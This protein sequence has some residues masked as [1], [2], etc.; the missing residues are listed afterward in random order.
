MSQSRR[1]AAVLGV[2][3]LLALAGRLTAGTTPA[4]GGKAA[5]AAAAG[6]SKVIVTVL[7]NNKLKAKCLDG[8]P[9]GYYF[10]RGF[11]SGLSSW[12]IHLPPG[13]WCTS[14]AACVGRS[15]KLLGS[16][17]PEAQKQSPYSNV[18]N[19]YMGILSTGP[20]INRG[21]RNWNLVIPM[22]CDGGGFSGTAGW[23]RV[24][25]THGIYLDGWNIIN[26]V[27]QH[28]KNAR[29]LASA[30]RV[31]LSGESAG[32]QA[33]VSLCERMRGYAPNAKTI[34][35]L[36]DAGFFIDS[37]DRF[38]TP[39]FQ[40]VA[41]SMVSLHKFVGNSKCAQAYP[42]KEQWRCFFPQYALPFV[43]STIPFFII[44]SIFDFRALMLGNQLSVADQ[45]YAVHCITEMLQLLPSLTVQSLIAS[46]TRQLVMFLAGRRPGRE[47]TATEQLAVLQAGQ[48]IATFVQSAQKRGRKSGAFLVVGM[49]HCVVG[50]PYWNQVKANRVTLADAVNRW[51]FLS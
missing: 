44:N 46:S 48:K 28:V 21:F 39:Y 36:M 31:L 43:P 51:Y 8:S 27:L 11:G 3:V 6:S 32:A 29:G 47:C 19:G 37:N 7:P 12:Q 16:S 26:T 10:R 25:G 41:N 1:Q 45:T 13:G 50:N 20:Y 14:L 35:C 22:Y 33:V 5:A 18:S 24:N 40:T 49:A 4:R 2:V 9:P 34:K 23:T 17:K 30:T 15:G 42:P 38:G